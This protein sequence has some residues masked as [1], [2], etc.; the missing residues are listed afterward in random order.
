MNVTI[1]T[2][3]AAGTRVRLCEPVDHELVTRHSMV[4]ERDCAAVG[5]A[6]IEAAMASTSNIT[7]IIDPPDDCATTAQTTVLASEQTA[8]PDT[9]TALFAQANDRPQHMASEY[10]SR[11]SKEKS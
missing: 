7:I 2:Q 5:F 6:Y 1:H 10:K 11:T 4:V 3:V 8:A 9:V